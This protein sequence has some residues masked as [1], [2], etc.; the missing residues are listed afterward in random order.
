MARHPIMTPERLAQLRHNLEVSAPGD[1]RLESAKCAVREVL[2]AY[3]ALRDALAPYAYHHP[4]CPAMQD[5]ACTCGMAEVR[6]RVWGSKGR[7]APEPKFTLHPC[8]P[9][10]FTTSERIRKLQEQ[11]DYLTMVFERGEP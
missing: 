10:H 1:E 8:A 6:E 3:V 2:D 4:M 5:H 11:V 9:R 7:P